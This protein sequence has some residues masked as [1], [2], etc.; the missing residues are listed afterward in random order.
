MGCNYSVMSQIHTSGIEVFIW[1]YYTFFILTILNYYEEITCLNLLYGYYLARHCNSWGDILAW[2]ATPWC[3]GKRLQSSSR[4]HHKSQSWMPMTT[5]FSKKSEKK[6][7]T[8]SG[9]LLIRRC[10]FTSLWITMVH[11]KWLMIGYHT[12]VR[13]YHYIDTTPWCC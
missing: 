3:N 6:E 12:L 4:L 9:S 10:Y 2:A 8:S 7:W 5:H 11:I 13:W 1:Q